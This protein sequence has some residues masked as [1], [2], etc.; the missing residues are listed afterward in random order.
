MKKYARS[1]IFR[2]VAFS[3]LGPVILAIIYKANEVSGVAYTLGANEVFIGILSTYI[4]A[5]V[6]A[7]MSVI[8]N[9]ERLPLIASTFIHAFMLFVSYV[10]VYL[11]NGWIKMQT[12]W[13][14][15]L[16]FAVGYVVVWMIVWL[17]I[18][19]SVKRANR[20]LK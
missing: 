20:K 3:G 19:E 5:F 13:I 16:I 6:V 10:T 9:I 11:V 14:F 2:G 1:F 18:R 7:G 4:L 15:A 12:M 17:S 8:Y